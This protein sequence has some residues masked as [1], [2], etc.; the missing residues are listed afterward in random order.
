LE[1]V[2]QAVDGLR[3]YQVFFAPLSFDLSPDAARYI[4]EIIPR[5]RTGRRVRVVGYADDQGNDPGNLALSNTR[6]VMVRRYLEAH[7]VTV[8]NA[9]GVGRSSA[10]DTSDRTSNRRV[11]LEA[12][13]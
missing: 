8:E 10:F 12:T 2:E 3:Y 1:R 13:R 5:L 9:I 11:V 4:D 6:A 7:G